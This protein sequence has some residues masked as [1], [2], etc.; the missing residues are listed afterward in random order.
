MVA[1]GDKRGCDDDD[2]EANLERGKGVSE[3]L[4]TRRRSLRLH[5]KDDTMEGLLVDGGGRGSRGLYLEK[6]RLATP[7]EDHHLRL[8]LFWWC[9][10]CTFDYL[11]FQRSR[12]HF[13]YCTLRNS[14]LRP[15]PPSLQNNDTIYNSLKLVAKNG[16]TVSLFLHHRKGDT[17]EED[18][19]KPVRCIVRRIVF[20]YFIVLKRVPEG[21]KEGRR[22]Q[23]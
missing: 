6:G 20:P 7:E 15:T 10:T 1:L 13:P 11:N 17:E 16:V 19:S 8:L 23:K 4:P 14:L 5:N 18:A 2:D 3:H 22:L 12:P 9:D 21:R